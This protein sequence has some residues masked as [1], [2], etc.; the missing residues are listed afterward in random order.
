MT[1]QPTLNLVPQV[2]T[3]TTLPQVE[4][5]VQVENGVVITTSIDVAHVFEK[6]HKNV[7]QSIEN[8]LPELPEECRLNFQPTSET[9]LQP[10]GG[11]RNVP[12]YYL[13]RDGF[14]LLAMGFTGKKALHFKLA[15]IDAFNRMEAKIKAQPMDTHQILNDPAAMRG[16]LL[17]YTEKV[18]ALQETLAEQQPKIEAL[19]RIANSDG[20]LCMRDSAKVLQVRPIDLKNWLMLNR[21]I[22]G[23]P[24]HSGWL[25]YQDKIQRG[26]LCHKVYSKTEAD[27]NERTFEQV[28]IT[29]KG[30]TRIG[31]SLSRLA[32]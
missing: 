20:S 23:R 17:T 8:L 10:N 12:A 29:P 9:V 13:T 28:R 25:G 2:D 3:P 31:E 6:Q 16:L 15:Y 26:L 30:L 4:P 1:S 22:Y 32:A 24:G 18:I 19:E 21:W 5:T 14:T 11:T 7:L 27:G